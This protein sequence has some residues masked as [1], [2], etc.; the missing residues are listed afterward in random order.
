MIDSV[1]LWARR[2][3][4][5]RP[6]RDAEASGKGGNA[7]DARPNAT[8]AGRGLFRHGVVKRL[9]RIADTLCGSFLAMAQNASGGMVQYDL[10]TLLV[11]IPGSR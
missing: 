9:E 4:R 11:E 1:A 6:Q 10:I 3:A 5:R 8:L 2:A 7:A